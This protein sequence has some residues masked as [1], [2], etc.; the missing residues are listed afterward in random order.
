M[1]L[2]VETIPIGGKRE[3]G[4]DFELCDLTATVRITAPDLDRDGNRG[5]YKNTPVCTGHAHVVVA[6]TMVGL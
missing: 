1:K 3:I 2:I 5:P 4:C 6:E